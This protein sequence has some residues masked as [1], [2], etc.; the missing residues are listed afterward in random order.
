LPDFNTIWQ[1]WHEE[2]SRHIH[3]VAVKY[4]LGS[5]SYARNYLSDPELALI[6]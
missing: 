3:S 2:T 1:K 5:A 4:D 6:F